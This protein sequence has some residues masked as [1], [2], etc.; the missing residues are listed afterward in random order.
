MPFLNFELTLGKSTIF[1]WLFLKALS[2]LYSL[3]IRCWLSLYKTGLKV[4]YQ[5]AKPVISIGNITVGGTGKTPMISWFLDY[6][7]GKGIKSG[8]L[9]RGYKADGEKS[10]RIL[11][12]NVTQTEH[13]KRY[14]DEPWLL[15]RRH[16][17]QSIF[18]FP[19]RALSAR[20]AEKDADLLLLDDGMQ[21]LKLKR[22]LN[23]VLIDSLSAIG[24]GEMIPLG[25]LREPL[26]ELKRADII[27]YTRT[28][29]GSPEGV[30][31]RIHPYLSKQ[32]LQFD[33]A[34]EARRL[35]S[36][37]TND[38][39]DP[40]GIKNQKCLL[41]SGIGNPGSLEAI[42]RNLGGIIVDHL[43]LADHDEYN[44]S[45]I[46]ELNAFLARSTVNYVICTEKDWVKLENAKNRPEAFWYF[47]MEMVPEPGFIGA[48]SEFLKKNLPQQ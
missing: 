30:K 41:F 19:D 23:I 28:N 6:L 33:A 31:K 2:L 44:Q 40:I 10:V 45:T 17:Q 25:P 22:D 39:I 18:I 4:G 15:H 24:N 38:E 11:D 8:V 43:I 32:T 35:V 29:I 42:V 3:L 27:L 47:K 13:Q 14:G 1:K 5:P 48:I 12:A 16:P 21:H 46:N 7:Q 9:T 34:F 36:A 26:S 37:V 20:L